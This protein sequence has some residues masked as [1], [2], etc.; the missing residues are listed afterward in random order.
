MSQETEIAVGQAIKPSLT[1]RL[2]RIVKANKF[3]SFWGLITVLLLLMA[4]TADIISPHDPIVPNF[5]KLQIPPDSENWMGTDQ[6]GRDILSRLIHGSRTTLFVALVSIAV[7]TTAGAAWGVMTGYAGGKVDLIAERFLEIM[8]AIPGLI[9]AFLLVMVLGATIWTIILAI[10]V[11]RLPFAARVIRSVTLSVKQMVYV[12]AARSIGAKPF[13]IMWRHVAPQCFAPFIVLA[14]VHLGTAIIIEAS[15]SFLGLGVRPPT[16]TWGG[17]LGEASALLVP[18]WSFV[19]FPGLFIT[20]AV[21][22]FNLLG[23][24]LRDILDPR[25]RGSTETSG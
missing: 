6:I 5:Q 7:G 16:P 23:D 17:M 22:A 13:R 24:G 14:T 15:L 21:L 3:A 18:N 19:V 20:A 2:N 4:V 9:L 1:V 12:E 8:M 10:A 11:T 25:L